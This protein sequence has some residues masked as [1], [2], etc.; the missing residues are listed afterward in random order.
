M[1]AKARVLGRSVCASRATALS[2]LV[3]LWVAVGLLG[4]WRYVDGYATYRG[5]PPAKDAP[6][7]APGT[8]RKVSF[9]SPALHQHRDFLAYLPPGYAREAAAGRR[10]PLLVLLHGHPGAPADFLRAG[11]LGAAMD[12][13]LARRAV[14]P[15]VVVLPDGRNGLF[16]PATQWANTPTGRYEDYVLDVVRA[17]DRRL[18]VLPG[19][20]HRGIGGLSEGGY[21]ALDIALRR[22]RA[23]GVVQSWSGYYVQHPTGAFKGASPAVLAAHSPA[24][25]ARRDGPAIRRFRLRAFIYDG[26]ADPGG[27]ARMRSLAASLRRDGAEVVWRAYRGGHDWALWRRHMP[28]MLEIAGRWLTAGAAARPA[29]H[30]RAGRRPATGSLPRAIRRPHKRRAR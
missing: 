23:F 24:V 9:W 14:P 18:A 13:L 16:G 27:A 25:L 6:G 17:A 29:E 4:A 10:F 21:G 30:P 19:R 2:A 28:R 1:P 7:V 22:P 8:V 20:S 15:M 3:V 11:A 12:D 5:F 26:R